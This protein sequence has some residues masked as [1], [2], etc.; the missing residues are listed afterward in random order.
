MENKELRSKIGFNERFI[1]QIDTAL[2]KQMNIYTLFDYF[3]F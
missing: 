2:F 3:Y 1:L